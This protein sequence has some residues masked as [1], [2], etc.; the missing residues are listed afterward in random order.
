MVEAEVEH[1]LTR[2]ARV[3]IVDDDEVLANYYK[4]LLDMYGC[5][6]TVFND[7]LAALEDFKHHLMIMI[8]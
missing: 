8:L 7:S 1:P 2:T 4:D 5:E 6:T 3:L